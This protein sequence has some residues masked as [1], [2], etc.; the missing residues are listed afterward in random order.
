MTSMHRSFTCIV[1]GEE[2]NVVDGVLLAELD[3]ELQQKI[4]HDFPDS[5]LCS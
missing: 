4:K 3:M 5:M 2:K 1:D